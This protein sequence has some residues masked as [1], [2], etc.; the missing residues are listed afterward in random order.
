MLW[1][2]STLQMTWRALSSS[3]FLGD[4]KHGHCFIYTK[5]KAS[6]FQQGQEKIQS[7][8]IQTDKET[9]AKWE[10]FGGTSHCWGV[11]QT[12][13]WRKFCSPTTLLRVAPWKR[14][15]RVVS[16]HRHGYSPDSQ[17]VSLSYKYVFFKFQLSSNQLCP[18]DIGSYSRYIDKTSWRLAFLYL[19]S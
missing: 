14:P 17:S 9:K 16:G 13:E 15:G 7:F 3:L 2:R 8:K 4:R 6:L 1:V 10:T 18:W 5:E 11:F 12:A 19:P